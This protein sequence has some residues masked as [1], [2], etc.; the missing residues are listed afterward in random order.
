MDYEHCLQ[1][2]NLL[3]AHGREVY[4]YEALLQLDEVPPERLRR[5]LFFAYCKL[6]RRDNMLRTAEDLLRD[7]GST[8]YVFWSAACLVWAGDWKRAEALLRS[9]TAAV[10]TTLTPSELLLLVDVLEH[11]ESQRDEALGLLE[12]ALA[13]L[14]ADAMQWREQFHEKRA[15]LL[16]LL[17][18][19]AHELEEVRACTDY[20]PPGAL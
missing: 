17:G 4:C 7:S 8:E 9:F 11:E 16:R 1:T 18:R 10:Q 12:R 14:G 15:E 5:A 6:G 19:P 3:G 20:S 13:G 2:F